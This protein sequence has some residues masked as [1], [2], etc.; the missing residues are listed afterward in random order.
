MDSLKIQR[1]AFVFK[2]LKERTVVTRIMMNTVT[3]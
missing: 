2:C 3:E 1:E